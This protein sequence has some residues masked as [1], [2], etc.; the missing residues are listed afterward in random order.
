MTPRYLQVEN[1]QPG[2]T[3]LRLPWLRHH[4]EEANPL[5]DAL[6]SHPAVEEVRVRPYTGSVLVLHDPELLGLE[7]LLD[8]IRRHTGEVPVVRAGERPPMDMRA[9]EHALSEGS[10]VSREAVRC[11]RGVNLDLLRATDG[12]VDLGLLMSMGF[13]ALGVGE[14]AASGKLPLPPWF[15]LSWW[16]FRTFLSTEKA[17]MHSLELPGDA[18]SAAPA[19]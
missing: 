5:A 10:S 14:V 4:P 12:R 9:L 2:R 17:A 16:A 18:H 3:R 1:T 15:S 11:V 6:S 7:A 13:I 19:T 8:R